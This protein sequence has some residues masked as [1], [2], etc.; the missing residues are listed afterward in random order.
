MAIDDR[1]IE[2][3]IDYIVVLYTPICIFI[4][5]SDSGMFTIFRKD[6]IIVLPHTVTHLKTTDWR[7]SFPLT[8]EA[9]ELPRVSQLHDS[10]ICGF[11]ILTFSFNPFKIGIFQYISSP[12]HFQNGKSR[13]E[14]YW[15]PGVLFTLFWHAHLMGQA[16][17]NSQM[18]FRCRDIHIYRYIIGYTYVTYTYM[19]MHRC[20][21][22]TFL[23]IY[24]QIDEH[25]IYAKK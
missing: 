22:R 7:L 9:E 17:Q 3:K 19:H 21:M 12:S 23:C 16:L 24:M 20:C 13:C 10:L 6:M 1:H 2:Y 4:Y 5:T 25:T 14:M 15:N 18:C 8:W 11:G